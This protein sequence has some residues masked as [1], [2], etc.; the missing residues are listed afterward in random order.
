MRSKIASRTLAS[1]PHRELL[2]IS[3]FSHP[4]IIWSQPTVWFHFLP[5]A[6]CNRDPWVSKE[7]ERWTG[8]ERV[9]QP[10][11]TIPQFHNEPIVPSPT[12]RPPS[13]PRP[14]GCSLDEAFLPSRR[15]KLSLSL[16]LLQFVSNRFESPLDSLEIDGPG[17]ITFS[18]TVCR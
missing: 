15:T 4:E 7:E 1:P 12:A 13:L 11:S 8:N 9:Q 14:S 18:R 17:I 16:P 2:I 5:V 6:T 10:P 3:T